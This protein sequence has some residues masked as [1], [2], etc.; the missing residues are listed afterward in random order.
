MAQYRI[1]LLCPQHSCQITEWKKEHIVY[2]EGLMYKWPL[3]NVVLHIHGCIQGHLFER[4][5]YCKL[6]YGIRD[7]LTLQTVF[8]KYYNIPT[9]QC[10]GAE[11]KLYMHYQ[12]IKKAYDMH[13]KAS[14]SN[15]TINA[16]D[17]LLVCQSAKDHRHETC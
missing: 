1:S 7:L 5:N 11:N 2:G 14:C 8:V 9:Q 10:P 15:S 12:L 17:L 3:L 6:Q 16:N 13:T 4:I